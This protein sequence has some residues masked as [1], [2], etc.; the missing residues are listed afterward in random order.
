[1]HTK[2]TQIVIVDHDDCA[3]ESSETTHMKFH[4]EHLIA[5]G[6][7]AHVLPTVTS[8]LDAS[9]RPNGH[10]QL[11][12]SAGVLPKDI[13]QW[14]A[15]WGR[16][17]QRHPSPKFYPGF[18][19]FV[20]YLQTLGCHVAVCTH[21]LSDQ[22]IRHYTEHA[23]L[24]DG[25][26]VLPDF[27]YSRDST[28]VEKN[29]PNPFPVLDSMLRWGVSDPREVWV[30]DDM[31]PGIEMAK[32]AGA[33]AIGCAWSP[34]WGSEFVRSSMQSRTDAVCFSIQEVGELI[35]KVW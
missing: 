20:N 7:G 22:V 28:G 17:L 23:V 1:M 14:S 32:A 6:M 11:L 13:P 8:W 2:E 21:G 9:S 25:T 4:N 19:H 26:L 12:L 24:D 18:A 5:N 33:F 3:V 27:V 15:E 34:S 31:M 16:W 10:Q 35:K 29:K 30:L